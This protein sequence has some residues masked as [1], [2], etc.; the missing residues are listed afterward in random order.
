[1]K[2]YF[3]KLIGP[4]ATFP[5][6]ITPSEAQL[7]KEHSIYWR[8]VMDQGHVVAFGPV[9]DPKGFFGALVLELPDDMGARALMLNDPVLLADVGFAFELYPMPSAVVRDRR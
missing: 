4:R 5:H 8:K 9:A 6:D 1:V 3:G 7:M 2:Y